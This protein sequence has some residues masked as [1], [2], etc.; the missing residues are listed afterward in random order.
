MWAALRSDLSE[1]VYGVAEETEG[2]I[3]KKSDAPKFN[4]DGDVID[5]G[6]EA[7]GLV[8]SPDDEV[9]RRRGL[10]ET[11]TEALDE[12]DE[13]VQQYLDSFRIDDKTQEIETL[14]ETHPDT[15]KVHFEA[16]VPTEL[17]YA[18]FWQRYF[19]RCDVSII[20]DEW[21]H[22]EENRKDN[23]NAISGGISSVTSLLGGALSVVSKAV[24]PDETQVGDK[25]VPVS[26]FGNQTQASHLT[27]GSGF[28]L[29]GSG[30]PPFVLNTAVDEDEDDDEEEE[31]LGWDDEDEEEEEEK[32]TAEPAESNNVLDVSHEITFSGGNNSKIESLTEQLAQALNERDAM[33]ETIE[34]QKKELSSMKGGHTADDTSNNKEMERLKLSL[35][36]RDAE[37]AALKASLVDTHENESGT[38]VQK[39]SVVISTLERDVER[40][41]NLLAE[42]ERELSTAHVLNTE[43]KAELTKFKDLA[44]R[45]NAELQSLLESAKSDAELLRQKMNVMSNSLVEMET[46]K[47]DL[48]AAQSNFRAIK[49]ELDMSKKELLESEKKLAALEGEASQLRKT[50]SNVVVAPTTTESSGP[51]TGVIDT[52]NEEKQRA[53]PDSDSIGVKIDVNVRLRPDDAEDDWGD[54]WGDGDG[55]GEHDDE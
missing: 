3:G 39:D 9:A 30:R 17:T 25:V 16:L 2:I 7:T 42:K 50:I 18:L 5:V 22:E 4:D 47:D 52:V 21:E 26:P 48:A 27:T 40:L 15:L 29:F 36:E 51:I 28:N 46:V 32:E 37:L 20:T 23:N 8:R 31:E 54:D 44:S 33:K 11:Y 19:F 41:H 1:F 24:V 49:S 38:S 34:L 10:L 35:F 14:L 12:S 55:D 13:L 43:L 6:Y 45:E 53:S